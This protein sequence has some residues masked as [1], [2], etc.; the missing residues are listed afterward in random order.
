MA[1]RDITEEPTATTPVVAET[2]L[3]TKTASAVFAPI[4]KALIEC[5]NY[6]QGI[7]YNGWMPSN[8][9]QR[10]FLGRFY[11]HRHE[12]EAFGPDELKAWARKTAEELNQILADHKYEIR[13]QPWPDNEGSFGVVAI[14]DALARWIQPGE[15]QQIRCENDELNYPG[16]KLTRYAHKFSSPAHR[17][18]LLAIQA[19]D[20]YEVWMTLANEPLSGLD[21]VCRIQDIRDA[22]LRM[23]AQNAHGYFPMINLHHE[24]DI[25]WLKGIHAVGKDT[26]QPVIIT[27]ALQET[28]FRMNEFGAH[29]QSAVALGATRGMSPPSVHINAP[30]YLWILKDMGAG[31]PKLKNIPVFAG[32]LDTDCW[33]DPGTIE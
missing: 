2:G 9:K 26:G 8:L 12:L 29:A 22:G 16:V 25:G 24:T 30:F 5:E 3:A 18:P 15:R 6:V 17:H 19:Q 7:V 32:Y 33:E 27:Q 31:G 21:L 20:N 10:M 23:E 13:L 28:K 14:M 1:T 4:I 11:A